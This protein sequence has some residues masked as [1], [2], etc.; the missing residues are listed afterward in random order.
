MGGA[1]AVG[2]DRGGDGAGDQIEALDHG[3]RRAGGS[4]PVGRTSATSSAPEVTNSRAM[5]AALDY[6]KRHPRA[7]RA[8]RRAH[9]VLRKYCSGLQ[10]IEASASARRSAAVHRER[11]NGST[12]YPRLEVAAP[13]AEHSY[14]CSRVERDAEQA[15]LQP[16]GRLDE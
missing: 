8:G 16:R 14:M 13:G 9:G 5:E 15:L 11:R 3:A 12:T 10:R 7:G 1:T 2:G 6:E 4:A